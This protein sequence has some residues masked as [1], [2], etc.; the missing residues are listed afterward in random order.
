LIRHFKWKKY[1]I[2]KGFLMA[3]IQIGILFG[4]QPAYFSSIFKSFRQKI[5]GFSQEKF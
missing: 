3:I 2:H 1:V 5:H 4:E